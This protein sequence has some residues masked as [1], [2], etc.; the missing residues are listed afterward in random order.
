MGK[1]KSR[2][3]DSVS[4]RHDAKRQRYEYSFDDREVFQ[5]AFLF[6]HDIGEKCL[7]NLVKHMKT[8]GIKPPPH[9]NSGKKP[10]NALSFEDIKFVVQFI[11]RY[12][13][14]NA[15]PMPAAPRG[16]DTE[17]PTFLPCSNS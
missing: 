17:P 13:E 12:S 6:L 11:E 7:K 5:D 3:T 1:P 9:G 4:S 14:D 16:R 15:L 10:H 8:N 2:S